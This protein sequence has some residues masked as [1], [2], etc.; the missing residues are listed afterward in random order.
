MAALKILLVEDDRSL[1]ELLLFHLGRGGFEVV[2]TPSGAEALRLVREGRPDLVLLDW[3]IEDVP[4]IEVCRRLRAHDE[5]AQV[6]IIMLTA[7]G[8]QPDRLEGLQAGAD[9]YV[10]KPFSPVEL[11][12]RIRAVM[13]RTRPREAERATFCDLEMDFESH[14]V[15]RGGEAVH[16]GP[17]EYRLLQVLMEN[18]GR[19]CTRERLTQRVWGDDKDVLP[20]TVN[21]SVRR[22]REAL[23]RGGRPD[24]IRSVRS[25]GYIL[26]PPPER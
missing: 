16:L 19:V 18:A 10:T 3:M 12:A 14:R 17:T 21:V 20:T 5:T 1:V 22:L 2:Q 13:R 9:D 8:E 26:E 23:N 7:R 24:L 15:W 6:P 11:L 25:S 4:G